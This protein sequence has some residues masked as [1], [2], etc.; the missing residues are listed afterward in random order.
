YGIYLWHFPIIVLTTPAGEHSADPLRAFFQVAAIMAIAALS[1]RYVE[2]PIRHGALGHYWKRLRAGAWRR[3]TLSPRA[4][5]A[6]LAGGLILAVAIAGMAGGGDDPSKANQP[7]GLTVA[8][9]ITSGK[10]TKS[11]GN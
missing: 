4:R 10:G 3:E 8:E 7:G 1:W 5:A 11:N 9:T 6:T 2:N